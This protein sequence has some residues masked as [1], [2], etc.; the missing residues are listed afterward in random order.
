MLRKWEK[1]LRGCSEYDK[2]EIWNVKKLTE[3]ENE[4]LCEREQLRKL[5]KNGVYRVNLLE[6]IEGNGSNPFL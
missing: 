6:I 4:F 2:I 3:I 1:F 5:L